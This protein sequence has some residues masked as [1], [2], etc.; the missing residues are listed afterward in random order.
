MTYDQM[1]ET[2]SQD[3]N[4]RNIVPAVATAIKHLGFDEND[5]LYNN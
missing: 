5:R 4:Y 2:L 3:P 1:L